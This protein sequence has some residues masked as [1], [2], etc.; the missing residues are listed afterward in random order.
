MLQSSNSWK[1][2]ES[3]FETYDLCRLQIESFNNDLLSESGLYSIIQDKVFKIEGDELCLYIE[4]GNVCINTPSLNKKDKMYPCD[5]RDMDLSYAS[6]VMVDVSMCIVQKSNNVIVQS[7]H[8]TDIELFR[9]PVMLKSKLC[10]L[11]YTTDLHKEDPYN[12]GGYFIIRGKERVIVAQESINYNQVYVFNQKGKIQCTAEIRSMKDGNYSILTQTK[13]LI[14]N[15]ILF[16]IPSF[17]DDVPL[18]V[19][20]G[21]L[22]CDTDIIKQYTTNSTILWCF[23]QY[24]NMSREDCIIYINNVITFNGDASKKLAYTRNMIENDLL[25]HLGNV[26]TGVK[27]RFII[28]MAIKMMNTHSGNRHEDDRDHI[29]NKRVEMTGQ[30]MKNLISTLLKKNMQMLQNIV[31]KK[32]IST[33]DDLNI[34]GIINK[35]NITQRL[36]YCFSTGN[37][38]MPK[39]NYI[40]QGV[41]QVL[42]RLSY[43]G[44]VSHLCKIVVPISKESKNIQVRQIHSTNYGFV[45]VVETPEGQAVGIVR[46]FSM[47]TCMSH[48]VRED[49]IIDILKMEAEAYMDIYTLE[50][51][52]FVNG[53][54]VGSTNDKDG[55]IHKIK[56]LRSYN[57]I[58]YTVSIGYCE[59]DKEIRIYSDSGRIL[60]PVLN[61]CNIDKIQSITDMD[62]K[63]VWKHLIQENIVVYIDGNEAESSV[64]AMFPDEIKTYTTY[65]EIHPSLM[66]GICSSMTPF[67]NH[68]QAPRNVY[69]AAMMK[70]AVG[71]FA[72]SHNERYDTMV[73][74]LAYP[75]QKLVSNRMEKFTHISEMPSGV[76]A[77]VAVMCYGGFN[78]EDSIL[79]NKSAIDRGLFNSISYKSVSTNESKRGTRGMEVI[80]VPILSIQDGEY[81]YSN[82]DERGI[83]RKGAR[84]KRNDVLVGKVL[85]N[86][87]QP[88]SDCSLVCKA[89]QEGIV[90]KILITKNASG[91]MHVK[92]KIRK[93]CLPEIGD[94]FCQV[95]AQKGTVGM[96]YNQEDMPFTSD[97]MTPDII[98]NPHAFPSRMTINMPLEMLCGK[99][100]ALKGKY[101]DSSAFEYD[102]EQLA[103]E[104]GRELVEM[105][106]ESRGLETM[107]NGLTGEMFKTK[108]YIGPAYYIRLKHMVA[109]KIHARSYGNVQLLN[110]QPCAGR[111]KEGGLRYGEMERDCSLAHGISYFLKERLYDLSDAYS[112]HVCVK[113]GSLVHSS[114]MECQNCNEDYIENVN[115]PYAS[116][117]MFQLLQAMGLKTNIKPQTY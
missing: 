33:F 34:I 31:L 20:L 70:Q 106:Y 52:I 26:N 81:D 2:I 72:Y 16:S 6:P 103:D 115:I 55:F 7:V 9:L 14:D 89:D 8:V 30:L 44:T 100:G 51:R 47:M 98:I 23:A 36:F 50:F 75:Q 40:R 111:S 18:G 96:V 108:I 113:C 62:I 45:D 41:S 4:F 90:D 68:S 93:L 17:S 80:E 11:S 73:N 69:V 32:G 13:L 58:P 35:F 82:L 29:N 67:T 61:V 74:V 48:D 94:K 5:A 60:R 56:E 63:H 53:I 19:I 39:S 49:Y 42:S 22:G 95:S 101:H 28:L 109:N 114:K 78:Q 71:M 83:V 10:N 105:G 38:G 27:M 84:V 15:S 92:I 43:I 85:Y 46:S 76:N 97:G 110:R 116:K 64:I 37:W 99:V 87:N 77:I 86:R 21:A 66:L 107:Y 102:G 57:L 112:M 88:Q 104:L 59:I 3:Y 25:P 24:Q 54:W 117:L 65:C 1:I 12:N 91:Y 79:M